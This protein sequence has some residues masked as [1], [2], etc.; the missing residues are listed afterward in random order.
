MISPVPVDIIQ[1]IHNA[2]LLSVLYQIYLDGPYGTSTR[3]IFDSDHAVLIGTGIGVTPYA[4][5]LQSIA[6]RYR[7]LHR[8]C[9]QCSHTWYDDSMSANIMKL[10]AVRIMKK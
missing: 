7:Q 4:S 2:F 9:P 6:H 3:E 5:I 8:Q 10:K 1:Q